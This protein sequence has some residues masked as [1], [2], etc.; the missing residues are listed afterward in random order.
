MAKMV[1]EIKDK[2]VN[3]IIRSYSNT[4]NI[5][6][7]FNGVIFNISKPKRVNNK[8][9]LEIVKQNEEEIYSKYLEIME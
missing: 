4:K 7:Y 6:M 8:K 5:K 3:T 2:K 9:I 1:L